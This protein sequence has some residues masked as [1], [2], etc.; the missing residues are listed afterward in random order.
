[1]K[2]HIQ[3]E[4]DKIKEKIKREIKQEKD[5]IEALRKEKEA[6]DSG[7]TK[8]EELKEKIK[9]KDTQ[10]VLEKQKN[11]YML[12]N[13]NPDMSWRKIGDRTAWIS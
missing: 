13:E 9:E 12:K 5:R 8:V 1:M 3:N 2:N 6:R 10:A 11:V 7:G 4:K